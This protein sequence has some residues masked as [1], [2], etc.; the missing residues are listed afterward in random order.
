MVELGVLTFKSLCNKADSHH[1]KPNIPFW[2]IF[3]NSTPS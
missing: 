1:S 2:D 3:A